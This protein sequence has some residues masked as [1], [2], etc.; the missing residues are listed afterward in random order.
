LASLAGEFYVVVFLVGE[1]GEVGAQTHGDA[2]REE[3]GEPA[4]DYK[5]C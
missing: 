5:V 2:T 4:E 3:L 1:C